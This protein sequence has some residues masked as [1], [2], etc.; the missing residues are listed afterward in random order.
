MCATRTVTTMGSA[1]TNIAAPMPQSTALGAVVGGSSE[2]DFSVS[3]APVIG[4][5]LGGA[6]AL[7]PVSQPAAGAAALG[8][9]PATAAGTTQQL[10]AALTALVQALEG[11]VAAMASTAPGAGTVTGGG[12]PAAA[13]GG[14][15]CSCSSATG[16]VGQSIP[17]SATPRTDP[18]DAP[19]GTPPPIPAGAGD[20]R[21]RMVEIAKQEL[22]KG[23]R[24]DAGPDADSGGNIKRYREAVTGDGEDPNAPEPWCADFASWVSR[25]AG[26]PIG[27]DG[28]GEDYTVA[29]IDWAKGADRW[30]PRDGAQPAPGDLVLFDWNGDGGPEHVAIVEK[31]E[32]GKVHTIGGN[33]GDGAI[34]Q[35]SYDLGDGQILGYV[36][37][38]GA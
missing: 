9:G 11:V 15:S 23:V 28:A 17:T 2:P 29:L 27:P 31:V 19:L 26:V 21:Q 16:D 12:A 22:A 24:E 4:S 7:T 36:P 25:Q 34:E 35:A 8:G 38:Q 6:N 14:C 20:V 1:L 32:G 10:I 5:T 33:E 3:P 37:P 13:P 30:R 18:Q